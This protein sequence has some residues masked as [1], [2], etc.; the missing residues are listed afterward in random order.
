MERVIVKPKSQLPA[1]KPEAKNEARGGLLQRKCACG[2]AAGLGGD[3]EECS[4]QRLQRKPAGV[5]QTETIPPIVHEVLHSSGEPLDAGERAFLEPRFGHDFSRVRIHRDARAGESARAVNALAYTVGQDVVF[6]AGQYAPATM[7]GRKLLAHELAH[8]LQQRNATYPVG[9]LTLG[10]A[11]WEHEADSAAEA[12]LARRPAPVALH[13]TAGPRLA[14]Q[15]DLRETKRA[16]VDKDGKKVEVTRAVTPGKCIERPITRTSADTQITRSK[17]SIELKYCRGRT[18]AGATGEIDY[19]DVVRRAVA[20]VPNFFTSANPEQAIRDLEQSFRKAEPRA[21]VQFELQVGGVKGTVTGTG[22]GSVA[23]GVSGDVEVKA[24]GRIG[25]TGVEG[26]VKVG[27]GTQG[28]TT[29]TGQVTITPG[30]PAPEIPNCF[31]CVCKDPTLTFTCVVHEPG[32]PGK[33]PPPARLLQTLYVPLFFEY[34]ET[35]P[36]VG[37]EGDY[38]KALAGI[39]ERIRE[40]Y[41][42]SRIEGRTSPEGPLKAKTKGGFENITLA[43]KRA[44][45][46]QKDLQAAL[47]KAIADEAG[48]NAMLKFRD[49][50]RQLK[51]ARAAGYEVKGQAPGGGESSAELFGIGAEG[52]VTEKDMLKHLKEKL[53]APKEGEADPLAREHVIGEGLPPDVR[54]E[55][56][57]AVEVFREGKHEGK[58]L[59]DRERLETIYKPLRR[60]LIVLNPPP[61]PPPAPVKLYPTRKDIESIVGESIECLPQHQDL[62][63]NTLQNSWYEGECRP[64]EGGV[65]G[66]VK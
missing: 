22:K 36:R 10:D 29:V 25:T 17:A 54:K 21:K 49:T 52:E 46:A 3:C 16:P 26:G 18:R 40:G 65:G 11:A 64:K 44:E 48:A 63:D 56:E 6:G 34:E 4:S 28:E 33:T 62:F 50:T 66:K 12:A 60:A 31:D 15:K 57:A 39:V 1:A 14:R 19:S 47:D 9:G 58:K 24:G 13:A 30:A 55:V 32:G 42:I 7:G 41:T 35:V 8:V 61:A 45:K 37:W 27:G 23:G 2:G 38:K 53:K 5:E 59:T 20:A 43:Q 51:N